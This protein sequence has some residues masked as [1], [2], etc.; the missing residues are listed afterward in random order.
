[1]NRFAAPLMLGI[2]LFVGNPLV[3]EDP[4]VWEA[5]NPVQPLPEPP[6]GIGGEKNPPATLSDFENPPTPESVRLGR[7]L[8]F[9]QRL[10]A[11]NQVSCAT[12]HRPENGFSEPTAVSTGIGGKKGGRKAPSFVNQAWNDTG[13][14]FWDGR[15]G[16]LEEQAGGPM[17]NAIEMGNKDHDAVIAK[18][19]SIKG[20]A[21]YFEEAFGS[22]EITI[23]RVTKAIA[24]YERTRMSGNSAWDRF[25]AGDRSALSSEAKKGRTLFFGN[26]FCNNCHKGPNLSDN[27][28][29]NLGVGWD[30]ATK[31]FA[32]EGRYV[33][34]KEEKDKGAFKTPGLRDVSKRAPY[35]HDGSVKTLA[36]VVKLYS[37]G[38]IPNPQLDRKIDRRFAEQLDFTEEQVQQVVAFMEALDGEGYQDTAPESFPQ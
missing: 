38:G 16:S 26:G 35:M 13:H 20:Y 8:F 9:D 22:S 3:A 30:E 2:F 32:D 15:A 31:T 7:W 34:T 21:K 27:D 4:S 17:I 29:H 37:K 28:F 24:D 19:R 1:M 25:M 36:E 12:C 5:A 33:V 18:L 10:S 23:D 6:L 11:D 14:F